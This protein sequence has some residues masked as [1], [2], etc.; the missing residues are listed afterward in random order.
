MLLSNKEINF[1]TD[2]LYELATKYIY[3][4]YPQSKQNSDLAD[5]IYY[6]TFLKAKGYTDIEA[7]LV[8]AVEDFYNGKTIDEIVA[9]ENDDDKEAIIQLLKVGIRVTWVQ[10]VKNKIKELQTEIL[11]EQILEV[12]YIKQYFP[13]FP[14]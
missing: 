14:L 12:N 5:K 7:K 11:N 1:S 10:M 2:E 6:E 3:S 9:N 4:Y 8:Q 13:K